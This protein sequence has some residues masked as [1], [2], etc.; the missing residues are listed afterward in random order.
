LVAAWAANASVLLNGTAVRLGHLD[1]IRALQAI[2][3]GRVRAM[4]ETIARRAHVMQYSTHDTLA[5][6]GMGLLGEGGGAD[7]FEDA[8]DVI[9]RHAYERSRRPELQAINLS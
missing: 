5:L 7:D 2:P 3:E 9:L 8:F 1:A 6:R 4:R